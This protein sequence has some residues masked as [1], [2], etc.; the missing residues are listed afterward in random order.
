[1]TDQELAD[2][3]AKQMVATGVEGGFESVSCSTAGNY[4]SMGC[5]QWEGLDGRGDQLLGYIDGGD[6]FAGR[7]YTDIRDSDE[8]GKLSEL[9]GSEQGQ[10]AQLA[11]LAQD[12]LD[13]Y[14]PQLKKIDNLDDSR[15]FLYALSWCPTS[16]Y[17]VRKFIQNRSDRNIRSLE[18]L[19]T[20]FRDEYY[21]G[22]GVGEQYAAGYVN[23][24]NSSFDY[25]SSLDLNTK[26]G[27]PAYGETENGK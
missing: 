15:C 3:Y 4:P 7:T 21:I 22:A 12:C 26:Y 18:V 23:R 13:T 14:I 19:R 10:D 24:A 2:E 20:M 16:D 11:I 6:Y 17:I 25:V 1:M 5:S 27:V 8:L 9:L